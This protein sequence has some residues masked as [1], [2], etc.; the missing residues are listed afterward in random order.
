M[1]LTTI[2]VFLLACLSLK[3]AVETQYLQGLTSPVQANIDS[4]VLDTG[5]TM[6]GNLRWSG[7]TIPGLVPNNLTALQIGNLVAPPVGSTVFNTTSGKLNMWDGSV[8]NELRIGTYVRT[9]GDTMTGPLVIQGGAVVASTPVLDLSQTW[10]L[11]GTTFTGLKFNVTDSASASA[12][13][14]FDFQVTG[15]SKVYATK[16]GDL[17]VGSSSR[18]RSNTGFFMLGSSDDVVL[19]RGAANTLD[20]RNGANAQTLNVYGTYTD[21]FNYRRIRT[22]M[23]T[24]GAATIAA[25]GYGAGGSGNTLAF[26]INGLNALTISAANIAQFGTSIQTASTGSLFFGS[27]SV[28]DSSADGLLL[29]HNFATTDADFFLKLGVNTAAA[30]GIKR[31]GTT[32]QVRLNDD[33]ARGNMEA[34]ALGLNS[35]LTM[36]EAANMAFGT[37]TGTK[38]G[39]STSQK[40]G[41]WNATPIVQPSSTGETVGFTAGGGTTVT[42]ASTFTGN[43]GATAYRLSDIVKHL[44]NAGLLAQ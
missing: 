22:T 30:A 34:G 5:D 24:G 17:L 11:A 19:A 43:V 20:L 44:K 39:G 37:T 7:T 6:T 14:L 21:S 18:V 12:S 2:S 1:K 32:L 33:S 13:L 26:Q 29:L 27:R 25:E 42:D 10:N 31:V 3:A 35:T 40:L 38:I 28:I 9:T 23:T 41:F 8:W 36:G 4:R 15:S 16:A